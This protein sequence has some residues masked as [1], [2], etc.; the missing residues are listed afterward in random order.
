M[1]N[2]TL[3]N[4]F[5][6]DKVIWMVFFFL[7]MISIIE[8]YSA[9]SSLTYKGGDFWAP[10][11]KHIGTLI[12]GVF[13][14]LVTINVPCKYFKVVTPFLLIFSVI[15]LIWVLATGHSTNGAQRWVNL[16]GIQ[17][18]P[19]EIAKGTMVLAVAQILSALQTEK[20]A[21]KRAMK[22]IL[23]VGFFIIPF[24]MLENLSTAML[25]CITV[26]CMMLIG[27]VPMSQIG[28]LLGVIVLISLVGFSAIMIFGK[29]VPD[30]NQNSKLTEKI[31]TKTEKPGAISKIFHRADTWKSRI[32]KFMDSK[33]IPPEEINLDK[34]GQIAYANIAI[35]SSDIIG[36]GPGNSVERD[37]LSQAFSDFIY[38]IIIE[39]MGI[40][41]AAFVAILYIIM[42]FRTGKIVSQCANNFPAFLAMGLAILLV[43][44]ALFNML[45]AVGLAPVTGQPL[46]L[47]SKGGTSTVINCVYVGVILSISRS[48][49][50][51]DTLKEETEVS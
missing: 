4:I 8:V 33:P 9:S 15:T 13:F 36:K 14:M 44:Q 48:A 34:D 25:L 41:G 32:Y 40:E 42:L 28:K 12:M 24:I 5:K 35:A 43:T 30:Q 45:V 1:N 10:M 31:A 22:Y 7:C 20:G 51:R 16:I 6:G 18:Q 39:E 46:P 27:R 21:E 2:K 49:A 19:S 47:V 26:L 29:N 38:A 11:I 23:I 3:G 50:K 17:F 37:F